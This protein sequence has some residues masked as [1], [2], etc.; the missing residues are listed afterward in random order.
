MRAQVERKE[1]HI[2]FFLYCRR[3]CLLSG[4]ILHWLLLTNTVRSKLVF[5]SSILVNSVNVNIT[6]QYTHS[7]QNSFHQQ[8]TVRTQQKKI[9]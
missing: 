8:S 3:R 7:F 2:I 9:L 5:F 4:Q 1:I 6:Y